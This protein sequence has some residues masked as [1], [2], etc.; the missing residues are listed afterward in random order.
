MQSEWFECKVRYDKTLENGLIKKVTETYLVDALSFTEA[1]KR[2][3]EEITPFMTGEFIVT[4]IKRARIS[5]LFDS[6]DLSDDRWFRARIAY[7]TLDEK[8]G[9]EKRTAQNVLIQANDFHKAI[10]RL[11]EGMKGTLG[12][13]VIVTVTETAIIDVFKFKVSDEPVGENK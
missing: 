8:T 5:E 11:D 1:E 9:V 2:F 7:I 12:E 10:N 13:W 4:D 6:E 3:I